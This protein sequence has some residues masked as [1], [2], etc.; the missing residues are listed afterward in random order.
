MKAFSFVFFT[1]FASYVGKDLLEIFFSAFL[2]DRTL[3]AVI[4]RLLWKSQSVVIA[5]KIAKTS[6]FLIS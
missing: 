6:L 5:S 2:F 1:V 3:E 4:K